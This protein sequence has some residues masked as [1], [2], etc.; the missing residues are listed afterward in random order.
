[1][2]KLCRW[3]DV[4]RRTEHYKPVKA[5]PKCRSVCHTEQAEDQGRTLGRLLKD[6]CPSVFQLERGS[7]SPSADGMAG[8]QER[9]IG[10]G[11]RIEGLRVGNDDAERP[12]GNRS[13]SRLG[14]S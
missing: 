9:A 12:V 14:G 7:A 11:R 10:Y 6:R 8:K 3:F 1:M 13:A 4:P 5:K 2:V